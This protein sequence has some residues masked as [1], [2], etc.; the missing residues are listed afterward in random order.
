[1]DI[2]DYENITLPFKGN[3]NDLQKKSVDIEKISVTPEVI[4]NSVI[5][6][7]KYDH[8]KK[9]DKKGIKDLKKS[10]LHL[11]LITSESVRFPDIRKWSERHFKKND[12]Q[13]KY[14]VWP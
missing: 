8:K 12:A 4:K 10:L 3:Y 2:K 14:L 7:S 1:M 5:T 9:H 11:I 13:P 6:L